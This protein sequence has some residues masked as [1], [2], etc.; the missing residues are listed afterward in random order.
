MGLHVDGGVGNLEIINITMDRFEYVNI[1][2]RNSRNCTAKLGMGSHFIFQRDN[3]PKHTFLI[4]REWLL[5]DVQT[6]S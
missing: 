6:H 1:S 3:G 5:Y 2:K 4:V